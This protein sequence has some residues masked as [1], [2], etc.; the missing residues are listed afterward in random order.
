MP[1]PYIIGIASHKG[2]VGKTT[3]AVNLATSL[4]RLNYK[5]LLI[6]TDVANPNI[7][8]HLGLE[9]ANIG[10]QS[11]VTKGTDITK[12]IAVHSP[13]GLS[14]L[15]ESIPVAEFIVSKEQLHA[16]K[17]KL[18]KLNFDFIIIDTSPG[19]HQTYEFD[20]WDECI[21]VSTPDMPSISAAM[22][23]EKELNSQRIKSSLIMNKVKNKNYEV[24][25]DEIE[26]AWAERVYAV[27]PDS[28]NVRSSLS[29]Q[30]PVSIKYVNDPFTNA[31]IEMAHKYSGR[32][33]SKLIGSTYG[34][35]ILGRIKAFLRL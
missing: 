17:N 15:P 28:E 33:D 19:Y 18:E 22:R 10:F 24:H 4:K 3:V 16:F 13:T 34:V 11:I 9:D 31:I 1:K 7:C 5:V 27:L 32:S 14:I 2:G 21:I 35:G 26:E 25:I 23:I 6:G 8:Y 12:A 30:I 29:E 20:Y